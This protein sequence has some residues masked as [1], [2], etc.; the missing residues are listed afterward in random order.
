[1]PAVIS[2]RRA[3]IAD[4]SALTEIR[5]DAILKL[6]SVAMGDHGANDWADSATA[7]R[8]P[9]AITEHEV[10]LSELGGAPSGWVEVHQDR[11]EAL[12]VNS[13]SSRRGL[14][15]ALLAHAEAR[16]QIAGHAT[17]SLDASPNA[18]EFYLRRGYRIHGERPADGSRP[19]RKTLGGRRSTRRCS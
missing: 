1:M 6:A 16:I 19:M 11:V 8:V 3:Q 7:D 18:E 13:G 15:S 12:Y 17:A 9:R 4:V 14:G 5:R 2:I 10:W